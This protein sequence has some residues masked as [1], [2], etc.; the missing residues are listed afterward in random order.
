[1]GARKVGEQQIRNLTTN[2]TGTYSV[3]VPINLIQELR[4]RRGQRLVVTKQGKKLIIQDWQ[5]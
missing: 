3:S 2:S 5:P 1:M 4:W